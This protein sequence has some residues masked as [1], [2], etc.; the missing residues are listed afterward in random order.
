MAA[1]K[2][3]RAFNYVLAPTPVVGYADGQATSRSMRQGSD[4]A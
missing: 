2:G 3:K 4:E 1:N